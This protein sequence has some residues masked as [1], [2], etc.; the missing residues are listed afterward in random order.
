LLL[1]DMV[2][3]LE[4]LALKLVATRHVS[5]APCIRLSEGTTQIL[6]ADYGGTRR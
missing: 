3:Q 4:P 1:V 5:R 2:L 6:Y